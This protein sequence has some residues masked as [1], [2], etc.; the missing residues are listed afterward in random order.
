MVPELNLTWEERLKEMQLSTLEKRRDRGNFTIIYKLKTNLE[1]TDRKNLIF[2]RKG[3]AG[4]SRKHKK[5]LQKEFC[6][7]DTKRTSFHQRSISTWNGLKDENVL[8]IKWRNNWT[9]IDTVAGPYV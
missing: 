4:S 6:L 2:R 1:E 7:N 3:E 5:K 9:N 8:Y